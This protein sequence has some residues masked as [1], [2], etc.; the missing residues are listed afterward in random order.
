MSRVYEPCHIWI[1]HVTYKWVIVAN[2]YNRIVMLVARH[3][4]YIC[5]SHVTCIW[6]MSHMDMSCHTWMSHVAN[7][8]NR[9]VMLVARHL[10]YICMSHVT[11]IW[12]SAESFVFRLSRPRA[13]HHKFNW[14]IENNRLNK[15]TL[16][17][18]GQFDEIDRDSRKKKFCKNIY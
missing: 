4:L 1:Y 10:L 12:A 13:P 9:I 2:D 18:L 8:Y 14:I 11:C 6:A 15:M 5:M 16:G 3:L 7:D 17:H